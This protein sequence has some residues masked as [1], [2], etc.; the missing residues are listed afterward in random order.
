MDEITKAKEA[1][2]F[3][4]IDPILDSVKEIWPNASITI[5]RPVGDPV[6]QNWLSFPPQFYCMNYSH[7]KS[8]GDEGFQ[9]CTR[10]CITCEN[11]RKV[12][13]KDNNT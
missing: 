13:S 2:S 11:S 1:K 9:Y 4:K 12:I 6:Y 5:M 3:V 10:Q 7:A 8:P